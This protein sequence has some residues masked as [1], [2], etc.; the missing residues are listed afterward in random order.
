MS[1]SHKTHSRGF[2][3]IELLVVIAIIGVLVGLLLPAVQQA[4]EA[5]RRSSCGNNLKQIG[6]AAHSHMDAKRALPPAT[7]YGNGTKGI[8]PA[9]YVGNGQGSQA[10][11]MSKNHLALFLLLPYMEET[12]RFDTIIENRT[13][14]AGVGPFTGDVKTARET[15]VNAFSCPSSAVAPMDPATERWT[16]VN[17]SKSNYCAN[18]GVLSVSQVGTTNLPVT[19]SIQSWSLGALCHGKLNKPRDITDGMSNTLMFGEVGGT[20][21]GGN[22]RFDEDADI[23]GVWIGT[24]DGTNQSWEGVRYVGSG[25]LLNAG[26][27]SNFGSSH[28]GVVGFVM[29][30]GATTFLLET[31]NFDASGCQGGTLAGVAAKI[32]LAK[33]PARGVL[34]KLAHR[35][36]GNAVSLP[37]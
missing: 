3:L 36:D 5:A 6:L 33:D 8:F 7:T 11:N 29:A 35:S 21:A 18:G 22:V 31:I 16:A 13:D 34:Q 10:Y 28:A 26:K 19:P 25:M 24:Q 4:R 27:D 14:G 32:P 17:S 1:I 23:C 15:P 30:D 20:A 2:T 12:A 9:D 37:E